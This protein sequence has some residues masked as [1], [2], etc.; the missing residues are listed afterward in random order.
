MDKGYPL[1]R[2]EGPVAEIYLAQ[3]GEVKSRLTVAR[4][5]GCGLNSDDH[6]ELRDAETG[7]YLD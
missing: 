7:G 2:K 4:A 3:K 1:A 5:A 6:E